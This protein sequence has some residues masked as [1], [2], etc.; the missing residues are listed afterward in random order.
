MFLIIIALTRTAWNHT[1]VEIIP[2]KIRWLIYF[3]FQQF[4]LLS[5]HSEKH[6]KDRLAACFSAECGHDSG[7]IWHRRTQSWTKMSLFSG[8]LMMLHAAHLSDRCVTLNQHEASCVSHSGTSVGSISCS[9]A[10]TISL[11]AKQRKWC[12]THVK[13]SSS[14]PSGSTR[15][16]KHRRKDQVFEF[17]LTP[18]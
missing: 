12:V 10:F 14:F 6:H 11:G 5:G 9:L 7:R 18:S 8:S 16:W 13:H 4:L 1:A 15:N 3:W 2:L 17:P